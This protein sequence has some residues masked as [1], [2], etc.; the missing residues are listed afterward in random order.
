LGNK[1][2]IDVLADLKSFAQS[3]GL[4]LLADHLEQ[5]ASVA[6]AEIAATSEGAMHAQSHD[7]KQT[8]QLSTGTG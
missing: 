5:T 8:G 3:N 7:E 1:W 4:V 2:I 6:T